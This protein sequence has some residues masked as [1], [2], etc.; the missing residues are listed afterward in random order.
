MSRAVWGGSCPTSTGLPC[1]AMALSVPPLPV[2]SP[3]PIHLSVLD[4]A[5]LCLSETEGAQGPQT[6]GLLS[7]PS[8]WVLTG[9]QAPTRDPGGREPGGWPTRGSCSSHPRSQPKLPA[10]Y[11]SFWG[12][13]WSCTP[14][15]AIWLFC[16]PGHSP[17][18]P[19]GLVAALCG[20]CHLSVAA[21]CLT[22]FSFGDPHQSLL[23]APE[24]SLS[25]H[26]FRIPETDSCL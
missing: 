12:P 20:W 10:P 16:G 21:F 19:C 5:L 8:L 11:A 6:P 14:S 17:H 24:T 15:P 1:P 23:S 25:R 26:H 13:L 18:P 7:S 22:S 3:C 9:S 4:L 2:L